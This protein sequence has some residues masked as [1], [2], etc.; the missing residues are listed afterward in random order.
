MGGKWI[1]RDKRRQKWSKKAD[2]KGGRRAKEGRSEG[3]GGRRGSEAASTIRRGGMGLHGGQKGPVR[4]ETRVG[5]EDGPG[6]KVSVG[7]K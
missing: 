1:R 7:S 3:K 6:M 4:Q 2:D 5:W